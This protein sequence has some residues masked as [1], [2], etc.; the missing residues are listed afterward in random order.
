M[1][2]R[3]ILLMA[4]ICIV[5]LIFDP[6]TAVSGAK[7]GISLSIQSVI[8]SLFPFIFL[9]NIISGHCDLMKIPML[10]RLCKWTGIPDGCESILLLGW[11]G[12]YPVGAKT[13]YD[14]YKNGQLSRSTA[15]RMLA[16]CN[17]AG[18]SFIFGVLHSMF[19][20]PFV[21]WLLWWTQIA[22]SLLTGVLLNK[23]PDAQPSSPT[24]RRTNISQALTSSIHSMAIICG[25]IIL[26]RV[27]FSYLELRLLSKL[28][29]LLSTVLIGILELTNGCISLTTIANAAH[30]FIACNLILTFGGL[31]VAFQTKS[32]VKELDFH[33]YFPGKLLQCAITFAI[34]LILAWIIF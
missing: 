13:V 22:S 9:S 12:G 21:L 4:L 26:F 29:P 10:R 8:P 28:S 7:D 6:V 17:N 20:R 32:V 1:K 30:R 24:L 19:H 14:N 25:W 18:P 33:S 27:L 11:I 5:M 23:N 2:H 15:A 34:S 31:C 16:F 3:V